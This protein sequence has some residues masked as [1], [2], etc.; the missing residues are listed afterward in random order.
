MQPCPQASKLQVKSILPHSPCRD[1]SPPDSDQTSSPRKY[2]PP[3]TSI[4]VQASWSAARTRR[5]SRPAHLSI[6]APPPRPPTMPNMHQS[7]QAGRKNSSHA[8]L[9]E[10]VE[11]MKGVRGDGRAH[12]GSRERGRDLGNRL[13]R[14]AGLASLQRPG[15]H[16]GLKIPSSWTDGVMHGLGV[17]DAETW[18][19]RRASAGGWGRHARRWRR[20][21]LQQRISRSRAVTGA[22]AESESWRRRNGGSAEEAEST[23]AARTRTLLRNMVC[24]VKLLRVVRLRGA[25]RAVG[26][27]IF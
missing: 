2:S 16:A 18:K 13:D 17:R 20:E 3:D 1:Q 9:R 21:S 12:R 22:A 25:Y 7:L 23:A 4:Y 11:R 27:I 19:T 5:L 14:L 15:E 10:N 24:R 6:P 26:R 8:V